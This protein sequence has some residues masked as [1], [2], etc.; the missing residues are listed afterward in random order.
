[1]WNS[2]SFHCIA[3][4]QVIDYGEFLVPSAQYLKDFYT[5]V[6]WL[7]LQSS[8]NIVISDFTLLNT[9]SMTDKRE[10][11]AAKA[12]LEKGS[13]KAGNVHVASQAG[14][15]QFIDIILQEYFVR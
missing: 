11:Y 2:K 10:L 4:Y 5:F 1:M 6:V 9:L 13:S 7:E 3:K 12:V 8:K 15:H 14:L